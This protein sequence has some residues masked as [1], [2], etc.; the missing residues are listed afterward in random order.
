MTAFVLHADDVLRRHAWI[1]RSRRP[2]AAIAHLV[3][4]I[5]LFGAVYGGVMGTF[6]ALAGQSQ[7][8]L[9]V[10]YSA[11]K[12]PLLLLATFLLGLP[13]FFVFNTLLGLRHDFA[14]AVRALLAAQAG[15]AIVLAA[16]APFTVLCYT[17]SGDY[18]QA[19]LF[20]AMIFAAASFTAQWLLRGYYQPL[21]AKSNKHRGLLWAW[22]VV[23]AFIG[24]QMGW[25][26]RPFVGT[27]EA[28]VQ[29]FREGAWDNAYVK[30]LRILWAAWH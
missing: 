19:V 23:Y 21:I 17:S 24:I 27:A 6:G 7:W 13:S 25:I 4:Y 12:V 9:Q 20:N 14:E 18:P 28:E 16:F 1:T 5:V 8:P 10:V 15:L 22:I 3:A 26:M 11:I 29:F 2:L 30:L